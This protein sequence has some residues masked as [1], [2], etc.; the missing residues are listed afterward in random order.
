MHDILP[1]VIGLLFFASLIGGAL[2]VAIYLVV[3]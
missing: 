2:V 1:V 3:R